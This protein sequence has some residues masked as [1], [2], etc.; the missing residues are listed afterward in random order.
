[1]T[2]AHGDAT[3]GV[4]ALHAAVLGLA[5]PVFVVWRLL[6]RRPPSGRSVVSVA[7][8][9]SLVAGLVHLLVVPE[10][11]Q[12]SPL[13][14]VF[15]VATVLGQVGAAVLLARRPAIWL[16]VVTV[17][18]QVAIT[19]LWGITR[20]AGIPLG[21]DAGMVESIG[22]LDSMCVIAQLVSTAACFVL[23]WKTVRV[24]RTRYA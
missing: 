6:D 23:V 19:Q 21:P 15:F 10:H 3:T 18:G 1:M 7:A 20:T 11:W 13:Y 12:E 14:G 8:W 16:C 17:A 5:V 9:S 4:H 24:G 2:L 22:L